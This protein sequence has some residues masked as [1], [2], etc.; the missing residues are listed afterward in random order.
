MPAAQ[1]WLAWLSEK[2]ECSSSMKRESYPASF[3]ID[4]ISVV[5][6]SFTPNACLCIRSPNLETGKGTIRFTYR[7]Y[8]TFCYVAQEVVDQW[9]HDGE[10]NLNW[11]FQ[12]ACGVT[13]AV[14]SRGLA[15]VSFHIYLIYLY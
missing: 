14:V 10:L 8:F 11:W 3:A 1:S 9:G 13:I 12:R 2:E 5:G 4:T 7:T 15:F 6:M